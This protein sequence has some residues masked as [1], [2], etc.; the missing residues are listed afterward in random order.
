MKKTLLVFAAILLF[1]LAGFAQ[2]DEYPKFELTGMASA[3]MA[4][5][6]VLGNETMWGW[7]IAGQGNINKYFGIVGEW[8]ANHGSS[9]IPDEITE[10]G[11]IPVDLRVQTILFGPRFSYR[12][13][14]VTVFG[15]FLLGAGTLKVDD[16]K[17]MLSD[18]EDLT[19]WQFAYAIGGG[20]DINL[21]KHF[22]IRPIQLDYVFMDS[23][24][25]QNT[26]SDGPGAFNNVRYNF[27]ATFKF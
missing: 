4:D 10:E 27:G 26:D 9:T 1:G 16:E 18:F 2:D 19:S 5:I 8:N 21:G 14:A 17:N 25:I 15:H 11:D 12:A 6:D 20:L 24:W 7:G 22:A 13:K 3:L 23:D